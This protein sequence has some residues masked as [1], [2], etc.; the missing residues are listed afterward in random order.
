M[1]FV[2]KGFDELEIFLLTSEAL[3]VTGDAFG[4]G[5]KCSLSKP[6][7]NDRTF[8]CYNVTSVFCSGI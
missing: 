4:N 7:K 8:T 3:G 5:H 1:N 6:S 2:L